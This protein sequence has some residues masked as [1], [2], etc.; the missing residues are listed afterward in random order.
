MTTTDNYYF[1]IDF[2]ARG[3]S[4]KLH[5]INAVGIVVFNSKGRV[6]TTFSSGI[7]EPGK[8]FAEST[9]TEFW[10]KHPQVLVQIQQNM[11]PAVEVAKTIHATYEYYRGRGNVIWIAYPASSDWARLKAFFD[12]HCILFVPHRCVCISTLLDACAAKQGMLKS[13]MAKQ[14]EFVNNNQHFPES[15][16]YA[17]GILYFNI[18]KF[19]GIKL[20]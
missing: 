11:R 17:Q 14:L 16:A 3:P 13:D 18:C 9:K 5:G 19:L 6:L 15:D 2:E 1:S 20:D 8:E 10:D 12:E 4:F 7:D